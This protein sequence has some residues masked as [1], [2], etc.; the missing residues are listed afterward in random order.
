MPSVEDHATP[1]VTT[2]ER[3]GFMRP[4]EAAQ[5]IG[6]GERWLKDG[7]N[8]RGFPHTRLGKFLWFSPE[9]RVQI[10]DMHRVPAQPAKMRRRKTGPKPLTR[11]A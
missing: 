8:Q 5:D 10:R 3:D 6:C 11:A 2:M 1:I 9:D 4:K 7:A